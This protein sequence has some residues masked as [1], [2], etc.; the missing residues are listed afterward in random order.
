MFILVYY[1]KSIVTFLW[2]PWIFSF[3]WTW[4]C[5]C[6]LTICWWY[7]GWV[8]KHSIRWQDPNIIELNSSDTETRCLVYS[9]S[10]TTR[11][12]ISFH[13]SSDP[14]FLLS[15][16]LRNLRGHLCTQIGRSGGWRT[17]RNSGSRPRQPFSHTSFSS[18][19]P[20]REPFWKLGINFYGFLYPRIYF[21]R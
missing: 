10:K 16:R 8:D 20:W 21:I 2:F 5:S 6:R 12:K 17:P 14:C 11:G 9:W 4:I 15:D 1:V 13:I 7:F 18:V 3:S 19:L